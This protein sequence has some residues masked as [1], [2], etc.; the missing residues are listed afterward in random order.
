MEMDDIVITW[1]QKIVQKK[2]IHPSS[3]Q[4]SSLVISLALNA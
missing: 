3:L 2:P 4:V 1:T